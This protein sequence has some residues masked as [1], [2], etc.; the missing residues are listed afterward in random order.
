M[1][2]GSFSPPHYSPGFHFTNTPTN[3]LDKVMFSTSLRSVYLQI[4]STDFFFYTLK[5]YNFYIPL[6]T[7]HKLEYNMWYF[8]Y[9]Q[10]KITTVVFKI[11]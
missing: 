8:K 2:S 9:S 5:I 11:T 7:P 6:K 3:I 4:K 1:I 10:G